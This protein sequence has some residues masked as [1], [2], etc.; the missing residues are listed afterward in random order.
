MFQLI[1]EA[2]EVLSDEQKRKDYDEFG[3]A[4]V[5]TGGRG[6]GPGRPQDYQN[7]DPEDLFNRIFDESQSKYIQIE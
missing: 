7:Y 6:S 1:A 5:T 3:Q 4:R 2:Y